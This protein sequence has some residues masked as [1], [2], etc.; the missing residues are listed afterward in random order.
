MIAKEI[1]GKIR[2]D[3]GKR[4]AKRMR[5][6]GRIPGI[7]YGQEIEKPI[8]VSFDEKDINRIITKLEWESTIFNLKLGGK[9]YEALIKE[10]IYN[11][12]KNA[13]IHLDLYAI[14]RGQKLEVKIPIVLLG[15]SV[16]AKTGG[17]IEH[18]TKELLIKCLPVDIPEHFS[19]DITNLDV[20]DYI[21]VKDIPFD[22][23]Y[24]ILSSQD[25]TIVHIGV[26]SSLK[27]EK[28][29]EEEEGLIEEPGEGEE[30]SPEE[31]TKK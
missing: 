8:S 16:G 7:F 29:E 3:I 13:V 21:K 23:K 17:V 19:V 24:D 28:T 27:A 18:I 14:K 9:T 4:Y 10:V 22:N 30:A 25:E 12:Y 6:E 2:K 1:E 11:T 5:K 26:P 20:N 31:D 15:E